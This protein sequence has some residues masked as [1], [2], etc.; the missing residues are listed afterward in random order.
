MSRGITCMTWVQGAFKSSHW[1]LKDLRPRNNNFPQAKGTAL[2]LA[3][4]LLV[5]Y[6][7]MIVFEAR[8]INGLLW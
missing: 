4:L 2:T 7:S 6:S 5:S 8:K 3:P 1:V